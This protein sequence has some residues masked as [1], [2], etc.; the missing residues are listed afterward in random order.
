MTSEFT[1]LGINSFELSGIIL[2]E[3]SWGFN[4]LFLSLIILV[5]YV[6]CLNH[7]RD[8]FLV[9]FGG[10]VN[11][12]TPCHTVCILQ[13]PYY[14]RQLWTGGTPVISTLLGTCQS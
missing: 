9:L 4:I 1:T 11:Y 6:S 12:S 13:Q 3:C 14:I 7:S 5:M 8:I 2:A 10:G